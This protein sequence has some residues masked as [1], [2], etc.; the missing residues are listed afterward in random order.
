MSE[1][2]SD[3]LGKLV[4]FQKGKKVDTSKFRLANYRRYLGAGS[5]A[6]RHDGYASIH[7]SVQANRNDVLMLWDGERSGLVGHVLSGVVSSTVSKLTPNES[8][9]GS[10]LYYFLVQN[11]EWIQNRRTGTGVPHV[12]KDLN[13]ILI[14]KYPK[15]KLHQQKVVEILQT[16]DNVIKKTEALIEKYQQIKAG[17][18]HDLFTR[19]IAADGKLRP[20]REQAPELYQET[21]IGWFPNDWKVVPLG[22]MSNIASGVTLNSKISTDQKILVPYLRVANVQDGFLDLKEVK[23]VLVSQSVLS[24]LLLQSGDVLMNEGGDFDKL[25]RGTVWQGEVEPCIHQNHVFRVRTDKNIL[26]PYYLAYWSESN[27]GKKYFLISSKQST[28]LA[29]INSTQLK[30]Y[31]IAVPCLEEQKRIEDRVNS[32]KLKINSLNKE[33]S[34]LNSQKFGLMDDLLTGKVEVKIQEQE[35]EVMDA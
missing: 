31:P 23:E 1:W 22:E 17:L 5:L 33:R 18:M 10:Y 15:D 8:I 7:L 6:G 3:Q 30:A 2:T 35:L 27:Y 25:G 19:G 11:F 29:S 14:V 26:S 16:I 13:R 9:K 12:P 20:P 28:N 24:N 34:K 32:V 4:S 21:P